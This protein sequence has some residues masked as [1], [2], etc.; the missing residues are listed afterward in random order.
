MANPNN[1]IGTNGAFGGRTSVNALNDV[2]ATFN[3]RGVLSGWAI[4]PSSGMTVQV[5]GQSGLRDVAIAE[6]NNGNRTTLDNISQ[7][8]VSIDIASA[9]STNSRMDAIVGYVE[10]PPQGSATVLDNPAACG[11]ISV[12]GTA[13]SSP[14]APTE[15]AIRTALTNEGI[16]GA[17]AYYVVLGTVTIPSGTT[18]IDATMISTP[19]YA[20]LNTTNNIADGSISANKV[21]FATIKVG[22]ASNFVL[23]N[24]TGTEQTMPFNVIREQTGTGLSVSGNGVLVGSGV[25]KVLLSGSLYF[26]NG[27]NMPTN[28]CLVSQRIKINGEVA[29]TVNNRLAYNYVNL[30]FG[31][32]VSNVKEGDLI[33]ITVSKN[34]SGTVNLYA[35]IQN[36]WLQVVAIG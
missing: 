35:N 27:T 29:Q 21:D 6:D 25:N 4:T 19:D 11:I 13:S 26:Y 18:D 2:L 33:T 34:D 28:G 1:A 7:A 32:V 9:P 36:V 31:S 14:S 30:L 16:N 8:P 17:T 12:S 24:T 23:S 3:G 20:G 10:N 15:S 5:G 22:Q